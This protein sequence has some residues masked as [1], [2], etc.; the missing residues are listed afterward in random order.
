MKSK[1]SLLL[2]LGLGTLLAAIFVYNYVYQDHRDIQSE[3]PAFRVSA[4]ELS[5][6]FEQDETTSTQTYLNNTIVVTGTI[7]SIDLN[8]ATMEPGI[9]FALSVN[10]LL[11]KGDLSK[12]IVS[13]KGRCIGYDSILEEIKFDQSVIIH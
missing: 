3:A 8:T 7:S 2:A 10:Q 5:A 4:T 9:F 13:I 12:A 11:P 6:A 1:K